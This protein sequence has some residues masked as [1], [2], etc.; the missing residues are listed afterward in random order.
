MVFQQHCSDFSLIST[1]FVAD[2]CL[3]TYISLLTIRFLKLNEHIENITLAKILQAVSSEIFIFF[4]S[5]SDADCTRL[6]SL[7]SVM[8][9]YVFRHFGSIKLIKYYVFNY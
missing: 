3:Q 1:Q 7:K 6:D 5:D 2:T 4:G 9:L 8:I